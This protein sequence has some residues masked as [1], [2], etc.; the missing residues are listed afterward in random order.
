MTKLL[1]PILLAV[2]ATT[3][4]ACAGR[5]ASG[6]DS[7]RGE[8]VL[9]IV[10]YSGLPQPPPATTSVAV[11]SPVV[12]EL[13]GLGPPR[14]VVVAPDGKVIATADAPLEREGRVVGTEQRFVAP[15]PGRYRLENADARSSVLAIV[16]A[17]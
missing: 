8:V 11:G 3:S 9:P 2:A 4:A 14:I 10:V 6:E 17:R 16:E 1:A 15:G 7:A 13:E 12:V 5:L